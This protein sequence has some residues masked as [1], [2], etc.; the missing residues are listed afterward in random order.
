MPP[1]T[2][3]N[4]VHTSCFCR[5]GNRLQLP[6]VWTWKR[7]FLSSAC[8]AADN[9]LVAEENGNC[10]RVN[11]KER[12]SRRSSS[13]STARAISFWLVITCLSLGSFHC[14]QLDMPQG[15][16]KHLALI[17][18]PYRYTSPGYRRPT[19]GHSNGAVRRST[20]TTPP[21]WRTTNV[22]AATNIIPRTN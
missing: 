3:S 5:D 12:S 8:A 14:I 4:N 1:D 7:L 10:F 15:Q 19:G 16:T 11:T 9:K 13:S 6:K 18:D 22:N 17:I 21:F 20:S 2:M